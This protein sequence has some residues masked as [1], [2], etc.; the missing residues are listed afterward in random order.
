[1][2][3]DDQLTSIAPYNLQLDIIIIINVYSETSLIRTQIQ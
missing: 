3:A 2:E 1:M